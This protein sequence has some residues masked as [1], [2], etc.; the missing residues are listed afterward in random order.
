MAGQ[1]RAEIIRL[2]PCWRWP[3]R[4][5]SAGMKG[6]RDHGLVADVLRRLADVY[7]RSGAARAA[8][9]EDHVW[10]VLTDADF[11]VR[12]RGRRV[13]RISRQVHRSASRRSRGLLMAL[14]VKLDGKAVGAPGTLTGNQVRSSFSPGQARTTA[15]SVVAAQAEVGVKQPVPFKN[16]R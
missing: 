7:L 8:A 4:R 3:R 9:V 16:A 10:Q 6:Y 15:T 2:R 5:L 12:P 14:R 1:A 11:G 13:R